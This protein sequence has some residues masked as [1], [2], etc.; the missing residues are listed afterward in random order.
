[1]KSPAKDG[2]S[3]VEIMVVVV[4]IGLLAALAVPGY[5]KVRLRSQAASIAEGL[6]NYARAFEVYAIEEGQW[7]ADTLPTRIPPEMAGRLSRF[8]QKSVIGG[9]W[10]W[11]HNA[12]GVTAGVSHRLGGVDRDL[13]RAVDKQLDDG[14]LSTGKVRL[15]YPHQL[16]YVLVP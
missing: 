12:S 6:R 4:L 16:T 13:L 1:M 3:L 11:E 5:Q 8:D 15:I 10:D 7:P 9:R 14:N 2:F